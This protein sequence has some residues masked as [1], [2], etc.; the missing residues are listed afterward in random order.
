MRAF[1]CRKPIDNGWLATAACSAGFNV[2]C[3]EEAVVDVVG[4]VDVDLLGDPDRGVA[5]QTR[6]VLDADIWLRERPGGKH[7]PERVERPQ[8]PVAVQSAGPTDVFRC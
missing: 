7:M 6:D 5:H 1:G 8:P 3:L 2:S 4:D